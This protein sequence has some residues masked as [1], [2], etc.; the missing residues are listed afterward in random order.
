MK[1]DEISIEDVTITF[2]GSHYP[3]ALIEHLQKVRRYKIEKQEAGIY[4]VFG[5]KIPIQILVGN[6]LS[7]EMNL[8]LRGLTNELN[9]N[10]IVEQL[11]E[12][13]QTHKDNTLYQSA[14]NI[15]VRANEKEFKEE[16]IMVCDALMELFGD[17]LKMRAENE[18]RE[19]VEKEVK[20][21]VEKEVKEKVEK[22]VKEKVEKEV[23][24]KVEKEVK[25]KVERINALNA[26]LLQL[27]R[28]DDVLKATSDAECRKKLLEEFGL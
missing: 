9:S 12:D 28:V 26:T 25:E 24:E 14:M 4:Y 6:Q 2:F 1:T 7:P 20:E 22:E 11:V 17:E 15:I 13:Y 18:V 21:K 16:K 23:K 19:K 27:G 10:E 8:W 5:D 3:R